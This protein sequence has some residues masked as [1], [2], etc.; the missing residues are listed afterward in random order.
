VGIARR[1]QLCTAF[2]ARLGLDDACHQRTWDAGWSPINQAGQMIATDVY[3]R[4]AELP[5]LPRNPDLFFRDSVETICERLSY[6]VVDAGT[7]SLYSSGT[8]A[9]VA[10]AISGMVGTVMGLP[11]SDLRSTPAMTI[12]REHYDGA[13]AAGVWRVEALRSTFVLACSSPTSVL[14]G[15]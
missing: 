13:R 2:S 6:D 1:D 3:Y 12:L 8:T 7:G 15:L 4:A 11:P 14:L 10:E 9:A 5:A